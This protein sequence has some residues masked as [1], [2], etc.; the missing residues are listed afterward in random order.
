MSRLVF[1]HG[2]PLFRRP[3]EVGPNQG[4]LIAQDARDRA[5]V[6]GIEPE[7][8]E[9]FEIAGAVMNLEPGLH[10]VGALGYCCKRPVEAKAPF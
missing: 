8:I 1:F 9:R 6:I 3:R 5:R 10:D 2:L 4:R 7:A